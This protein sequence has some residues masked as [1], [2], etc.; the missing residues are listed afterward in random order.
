MASI[1][2]AGVLQ[3]VAVP[4]NLLAALL[5][6]EPLS[7]CAIL[8]VNFHPVLKVREN[9]NAAVSVW[10]N[11]SGSA[12]RGVDRHTCRRFHAD[13]AAFQPFQMFYADRHRTSRLY[14]HN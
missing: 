13:A 14:N 1:Q 5:L 10:L 11:A 12:L 4:E 7:G 3:D 9:K 2:K 6:P 8:G